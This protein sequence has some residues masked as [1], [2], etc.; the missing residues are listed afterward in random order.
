MRDVLRLFRYGF[1]RWHYVVLL[2]AVSLLSSGIGI[3]NPWPIKIIVDNLLGTDPLQ[4]P[5]STLLP[6]VPG[7]GDAALL[8]FAVLFFVVLRLGSGAVGMAKTYLQTVFKQDLIAEMRKKLFRHL[9][10]LGLSTHIDR[11]VGDNIYRL[12]QD[13]RSAP[14]IYK[15]VALPFVTSIVTLVGMFAV[16][17]KL[18]TSLTLVALIVLPF[19]VVSTAVF[20]RKVRVLSKES[21]QRTSDLFSRIKES[22]SNIHIVKAFA[23]EGYEQNLFEK[24]NEEALR[25]GLR[26]KVFEGGLS[27]ITATITTGG[28]AL[29]LWFG[30]KE[31]L[32]GRLSIGSLLVFISYLSTMH[33]EMVSVVSM[34]YT[35]QK[36]MVSARRMFEVLDLPVLVKDPADPVPLERARGE[37]VFDDVTFAYLEDRPVLERISFRAR[38]GEKIAIVGRTGAGKTTL[39]NLILRLY[40][41]TCGRILLDGTDLRRY[42]QK[43]IRSQI[44]IVTQDPFLFDATVYENIRYGRLDASRKEIA[45]AARR[46]DAYEFIED[47]PEGFETRIA[48][49][50]ARLSGGQKQRLA[51]ARAF[52]KDAPILVLDEPTSALDSR[53][54]ARVL[55]AARRLQQDRT[56]FIVA[57]RLSTAME[58]DRVLVLKDG[59][60]V[61]DGTAQALVEARGVFHDLFELQ[62]DTHTAIG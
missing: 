6:F 60:L 29:V 55:D 41:P 17:W 34:N 30:A 9:Q 48:E 39:V 33:G 10:Y 16:M 47:L 7:R 1:H 13:T 26:L 35:L 36:I 50:A 22:F 43:D 20:N 11:Q 32:A 18:H 4:E 37:I 19:M 23:R 12:I 21:Y 59:F 61:E 8:V 46:A 49:G 14:D 44:S 56:T 27:F 24:T 5:F 42:R 25:S 52:L 54:E 57:H 31:A 62:L 51:I 40:D 58:A 28:K 45:S 15:G 53:S 2:G 38:P 3:L